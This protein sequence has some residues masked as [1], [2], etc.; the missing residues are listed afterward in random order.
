MNKITEY[1]VITLSGEVAPHI[2]IDR[3]DGSFVTMTKE[4]WEEQQAVAKVY[5]AKIK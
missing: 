4:Y 1:E 2:Q 5:E 3:P